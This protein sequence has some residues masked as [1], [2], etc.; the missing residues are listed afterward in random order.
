[1]GAGRL[2]QAATA[3]KWAGMRCPIMAEAKLPGAAG[4]GRQSNIITEILML[5]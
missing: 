5:Y 4:S 3:M 2:A 1:M